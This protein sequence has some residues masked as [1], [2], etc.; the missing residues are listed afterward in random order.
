ME[1]TYPAKKNFPFL[2]NT[3]N[4]D[5]RVAFR[6][7]NKETQERTRSGITRIFRGAGN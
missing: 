4:R 1:L 5:A 3:T 2:R 7:M 6:A